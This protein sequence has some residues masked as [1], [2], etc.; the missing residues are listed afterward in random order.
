MPWRASLVRISI[1]MSS[2]MRSLRLAQYPRR[3]EG[4]P[5]RTAKRKMTVGSLSR[6]TYSQ[7][8]RAPGSVMPR[9]ASLV[10]I[11]IAM[12]SFM[13]SLRLAQYPR[14]EEGRPRRTAKRKMIVGRSLH[15][16][17][18]ARQTARRECR[19]E[20]SFTREELHI[21]VI[22]YAVFAAGSVLTA[23]PHSTCPPPIARRRCG[24]TWLRRR[25][26]GRCRCRR[27]WP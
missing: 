1:A 13:R 2:F 23:A 16:G 5:R 20:A 22:L 8:N 26:A 17:V 7:I 11:S 6:R 25:R 14:R 27:S 21:Y 3:E 10:R 19:A 9:R 18:T 12:S 15:V 24:R 4:R